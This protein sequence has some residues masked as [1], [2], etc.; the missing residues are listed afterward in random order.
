MA[1]I[2]KRGAYYYADFRRQNGQRVKVALRTSDR[3][4]ARARARSAELGQA[5]SAANAP[6][7]HL[8]HAIDEMVALKR[9]QTASQYRDKAKH[10][11]RLLPADDINALTR[12]IVA[13]YST[14][15]IKEGAVRHTVHKEL[16]VL[17][18]ALKEARKRGTYRGSI[19][20][21][22]EWRNDYQ[23][24]KRALSLAEFRKLMDACP[25]EHQSWLMLQAYTSA[26]L[27]ETRR[28]AWSHVDFERG[29]VTVPGTKRTSRHRIVPLHP[30]LRAWLS[31]QDQRLPL[32][33][34]W[35]GVKRQ[36]P[37]I[38]KSAGIAHVTTND[39]RRTFGSWLKQQG[40]DSL[41]VAHMMGHKGT[42]MVDAV[43]GQLSRESYSAAIAKMPHFS[44]NSV[45]YSSQSK[46]SKRASC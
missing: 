37:A 11:L 45:P 31:G 43:Y 28:M 46:P 34:P 19:D 1:K 3:E 15:R 7:K 14:T 8:A 44:Q 10:L 23:P 29:E 21:V 41:H 12:E 16:V 30:S 40:V 4:V 38:A 2:F 17:R 24:R 5:D 6:Q 18:Q 33:A 35:P 26:N 13:G 39:L 27:S 42:T 9:D 20:V 22:P 25:P 36:L 32:V